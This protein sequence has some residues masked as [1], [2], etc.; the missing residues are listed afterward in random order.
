[1][2]D[3]I[4]R[5][6]RP[7]LPD[8]A[9][10]QPYLE[11]IWET[12]VL[13]NCG[14]YHQ[15]LE[16]AL[17]EYLGV[18]YVALFNNATIGL[19]VALKALDLQGEVITTPYSFVATSHA[20]LWTNLT[21]VFVDVEPVGLNIDPDAIE[22]A[23]TPRT[24][25]ILPVHCYGRPCDMDR[26]EDIAARHG[27]KVICDA[28]HAFGVRDEGGSVLRRGDLSVVSFHA[29]KVFNTFEGGAVICKTIEM[30][31]HIDR[32]KNFG[33]DGEV[34]VIET[35][36]NGKMNE[37]SS[38]FGLVQLR[39]IDG[40]IARR[41]EIDAA[42]R[43]AL[44]AVPGIH[45]LA[46]YEGVRNFAYFPVLVG[47]EFPLSRDGLY[48]YLKERGVHARKYFYPLITDFPMYSHLPS[49]DRARL[50]VA[51]DGADRVLCLP[52]YPDL[53]DADVARICALIARA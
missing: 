9:E 44:E 48:D 30:K 8:L 4:I 1:M 20:L 7:F 3:S 11:D 27:L 36:I 23:I 12:H 10:F 51:A 34:R 15:R 33:H 21:P 22:A 28:A 41:G 24:T 19:V 31:E 5:V 32:L 38:A 50:P 37:I 49:A 17:A 29:T 25:A 26:I 18:P 52:I 35:G 13:S 6:T 53:S 47:A 45:C 16:A 43:A 46:P 39:H 2:T 14:P 42:Y 40:A